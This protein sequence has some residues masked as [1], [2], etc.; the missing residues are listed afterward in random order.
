[1]KKIL[2]FGFLLI[3]SAANAWTIG[4]V[5]YLKSCSPAMTVTSILPNT[6]VGVNWFSG[7]ILQ[8]GTFPENTLTAYFPCP[9][10]AHAQRVIDGT[11]NPPPP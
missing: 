8:A 4:D 7:Q 5:V 1:M 9:A 6:N 2:V 10:L 11:D 3:S